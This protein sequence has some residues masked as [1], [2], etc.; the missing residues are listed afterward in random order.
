MPFESGRKD[1][2][3][4]YPLQGGLLFPVSAFKFVGKK[5]IAC[6]PNLS[7]VF[8]RLRSFYFILKHP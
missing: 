3:D 7:Y 6:R 1:H 4:W 5:M 8:C 2:G